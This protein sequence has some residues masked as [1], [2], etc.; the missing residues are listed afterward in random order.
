MEAKVQSIRQGSGDMTGL[1]T[2]G[3]RRTVLQGSDAD[4]SRRCGTRCAK[5][6]D[7]RE[8]GGGCAGRKGKTYHSQRDGSP[9]VTITPIEGTR[10]TD[11]E[12]HPAFYREQE[13]YKGHLAPGQNDILDLLGLY[14]DYDQDGKPIMRCDRERMHSRKSGSHGG[15]PRLPWGWMDLGTANLPKTFDL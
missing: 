3:E 10:L 9:L 7:C 8:K 15:F 12:F 2:D 6:A 4:V 1:P 5:G 14:A 11:I 13:N